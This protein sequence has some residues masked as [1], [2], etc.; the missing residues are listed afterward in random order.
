MEKYGSDKPDL[1][2]DLTVTDVTKLF[3]GSEFG[4]FQ[5]GNVIKAV[6]VSDFKGAQI[7]R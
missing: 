1:R 5:D 6:V 7:Y 2:I 3:E 4:P